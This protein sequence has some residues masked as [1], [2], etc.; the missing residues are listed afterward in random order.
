M[1]SLVVTENITV[2]GVVDQD[3]GWWHLDD[4]ADNVDLIAVTNEQLLA[5]EAFLF[6]RYTFEAMRRFWPRQEHDSTGIAEYLDRVTKY[7]VSSS[8]VDP[9]WEGTVVLSGDL[10]QEVRRLKRPPGRDIVATGSIRLVQALQRLGLVDEYRLFV[11]PY[12]VGRGRRLFTDEAVWRDLRLLETRT[13][14]SGIVM[15]RYAQG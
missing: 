6:G 3:G 9:D 10:E 4:A 1:R 2:D 14:P 7:V 11:Y 13:F 15:L 5:A 8:L 12:L